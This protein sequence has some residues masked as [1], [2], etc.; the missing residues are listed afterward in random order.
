MRCRADLISLVVVTFLLG[1]AGW[2][3]SGIPRVQM[4]QG[5]WVA[6]THEVLHQLEILSN[7]LLQARAN[8]SY[9]LRPDAAVVEDEHLRIVNE[10]K[11]TTDSLAEL[12]ADNAAQAA[13]IES[14]RKA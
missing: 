2:Y 5:R 12:T 3:V 4:E 10:L 9:A 11:R 7:R 1:A 8:R 6:H 13:R 14:L